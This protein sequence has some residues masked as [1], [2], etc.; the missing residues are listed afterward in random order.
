MVPIGTIVRPAFVSGLVKVVVGL[1]AVLAIGCSGGAVEVQASASAP[2]PVETP[3]GPTPSPEVAPTVAPVTDPTPP[4]EVAPPP[5]APP[6]LDDTPLLVAISVTRSDCP[7]GVCARTEVWSDGVIRV[8][9]FDGGPQAS[10]GVASPDQLAELVTSI[11]AFPRELTGLVRHAGQPLLCRPDVDDGGR[12]MLIRRAGR[13]D[14]VD[15][16]LVEGPEVDGLF[17]ALPAPA[18]G[19]GQEVGVPRPLADVD[20]IGGCDMIGS[21]PEE[22][23]WTDG[24]WARWALDPG[25]DFYAV[26]SGSVPAADATALATRI[27]QT[28]LEALRAGLGPGTCHACVDGVNVI[29]DLHVAGGIVSFSDVDHDLDDSTLFEELDALL[30]AAGSGTPFATILELNGTYAPAGRYVTAGYL[31][32]AD[33]CGYCPEGALCEPCA[34]PLL[35]VLSERGDI[36]LVAEGAA[37]SLADQLG[38]TELALDVNLEN[39]RDLVAGGRYEMTVVLTDH[40]VGADGHR[41]ATVLSF[42]ELP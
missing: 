29:V 35:S 17:D 37:E 41:V 9:R 19:D 8:D 22:T 15:T 6:A 30:G 20:A 14:I 34:G 25:E 27:S 36:E 23:L 13:L 4:P 33:D 18:S 40:V 26:A 5:T 24:R 28:D 16:C 31:V 2:D 39:E 32:F 42:R 12:Q 38:P 21:C 3:P 10:I 11:D 7:D 1:V